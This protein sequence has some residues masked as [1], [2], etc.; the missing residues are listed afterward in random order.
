MALK[1]REED[2]SGDKKKKKRVGFVAIGIVPLNRGRLC[3]NISS[4]AFSL[5]F[6]HILRVLEV[7]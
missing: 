6:S 5:W 1:R 7:K 3:P 4:V 2:S